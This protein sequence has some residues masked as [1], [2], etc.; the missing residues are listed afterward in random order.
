MKITFC[1]VM[2]ELPVTSNFP[3]FLSTKTIK[4]EAGNFAVTATEGRFYIFDVVLS[5]AYHNINS[6]ISIY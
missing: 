4:K 3:I 1:Q 6:P 2:N 5:V